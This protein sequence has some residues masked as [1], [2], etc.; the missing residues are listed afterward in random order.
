MI[1]IQ[2]IMER[3]TEEESLKPHGFDGNVD[4]YDEAIVGITTEGQLVYSREKMIELCAKQ[5]EMEE[6]DAI[7]WLE[8]NTFCAYVGE[9][10][11][12]YIYTGTGY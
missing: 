2:M 8:F 7:E 5:G 4:G 3:A 1:D 6:I 9:K 10:T 11:P 12:I